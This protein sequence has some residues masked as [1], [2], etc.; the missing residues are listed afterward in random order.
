MEI[1][2]ITFICFMA[3]SPSFLTNQKSCA[4][5]IP[6]QLL[7]AVVKNCQSPFAKNPA[8]CFESYI[9]LAI[10]GFRCILRGSDKV[11]PQGGT[12]MERILWQ[13]RKK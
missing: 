12:G 1:C 9:S 3:I 7:Y 5:A 2:N 11:P 13:N 10:L 6:F 4:H 8:K